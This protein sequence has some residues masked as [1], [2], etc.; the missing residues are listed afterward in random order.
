MSNEIDVK[1]WL[2]FG[3][4]LGISVGLSL[5]I[6]PLPAFTIGISTLGISKIAENIVEDEDTKE[7][8]QFIGDCGTDVALGGVLGGVGGWIASS[9]SSSVSTVKT[10]AKESIKYQA[11]KQAGKEIGKLTA[12]K[13]AKGI[14]KEI[15]IKEAKK[16]VAK[17]TAEI[18]SK[19]LAEEALKK[20]YEQTVA[21][22]TKGLGEGVYKIL[23]DEGKFSIEEMS[24]HLEHLNKE[25]NFKEDCK[26]CLSNKNI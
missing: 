4:K 5:V 12:E 15:A 24:F 25:N 7:V 8:F 10:I 18:I 11:K 22:I 19:K 26:I 14:T 16:E 23:K 13:I 6:S 21:A 9:G 1:K 2:K 17:R 20:S 3:A